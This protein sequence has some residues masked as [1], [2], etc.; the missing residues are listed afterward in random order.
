MAKRGGRDMVP[1]LLNFNRTTDNM[2]TCMMKF[3]LLCMVVIS[4][5]FSVPARASEYW[6][7]NVSRES[8]WNDVPQEG[9][10]CWAM[11][12][13]NILCWWQD[14]LEKTYLL[15]E[16]APRK[17]EDIKLSLVN[18]FNRGDQGWFVAR[19]FAWYL[20]TYYSSTVKLPFP[21]NN[22]FVE[23]C[24]N[25]NASYTSQRLKELLQAGVPVSVANAAHA[26]TVWGVEYNDQ[27]N[28][29]SKIW[30]T[31][32]M[33][34][35]GWDGLEE[36]NVQIVTSEKDGTE[37]LMLKLASNPGE[38]QTWSGNSFDYLLFQPGDITLPLVPE[39]SVSFLM[40]AGMFG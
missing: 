10:E 6:A 18:H 15:P 33:P 34:N 3:L 9:G 25:K 14:E 19:A 7:K 24:T 2:K 32:S 28:S 17:F 31:N 36:W 4:S 1:S 22:W 26:V 13:S 39:P 38:Q 40:L 30:L 27:S 29:L 16:D 21:K 23:N 37:G 8:G 11:V 20:E 35:A 5:F 12:A